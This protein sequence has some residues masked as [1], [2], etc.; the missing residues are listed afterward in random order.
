MPLLIPF[1]L[2]TDT[3]S[4]IP[5]SLQLLGFKNID[6]SCINSPRPVG[7]SIHLSNESRGYCTLT[8]SSLPNFA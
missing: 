4:A 7:L 8:S 3:V 2:C 5:H 6:M 1:L